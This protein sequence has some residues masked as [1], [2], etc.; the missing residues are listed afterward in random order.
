MRS[1]VADAIARPADRGGGAR[2]ADGA[3]NAAFGRWLRLRRA[4][5]SSPAS[6]A[7][8]RKPPRTARQTLHPLNAPWPPCPSQC[9]SGH[10]SGAGTNA[11]TAKP[12]MM[13]AGCA[14]PGAP[15]EAAPM[16]SW[17]STLGAVC[18]MVC[19]AAN[20]TRV[21]NSSSHRAARPRTA[22]SAMVTATTLARA[23]ARTRRAPVPPTRSGRPLRGEKAARDIVAVREP[24]RLSSADG[25]HVKAAQHRDPAASARIPTARIATRRPELLRSIRRVGPPRLP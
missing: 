25:E 15:A 11:V 3:V 22:V 17:V 21:Q 14:V 9:P 2:G 23:S 18:P 7:S 4:F 16:R 5:S 6:S 12:A 10:G 1:T 19:M 13:A 20:P 8:T 24:A